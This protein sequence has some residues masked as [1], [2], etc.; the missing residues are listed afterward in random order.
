MVKETLK[1]L[2]IFAE[3]EAAAAPEQ[4]AAME[5]AAPQQEAAP[6]QETAG[7][8]KLQQHFRSLQMQSEALKKM[9][10][11]FDFIKEMQNPAFVRLTAP[12]TGIGVEDAYYALHRKEIQAAAMQVTAQM[13]AQKISNSIQSGLRRPAENGTSGQGASV[14]TF[15]YRGATKEQRNALKKRILDEAAQ[16]R[17][18][19]P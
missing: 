4:E 14:T 10:P 15:D 7:D 9:F 5:E 6:A 12:D 3:E 19:Y 16:G 8:E 2:Q 17:K 11:S 18:V 1:L 13:T